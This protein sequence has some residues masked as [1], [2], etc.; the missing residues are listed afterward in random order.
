MEFNPELFR[1]RSLGFSR[2]GLKLF[3]SGKYLGTIKKITKVADVVTNLADLTDLKV[4]LQDILQNWERDL[5]CYDF[6]SVIWRDSLPL[7]YGGVFPLETY[8]V[9]SGSRS[10]LGDCIVNGVWEKLPQEAALR[11]F[12]GDLFPRVYGCKMFDYGIHCSFLRMVGIVAGN[13][14]VYISDE[15]WTF[16]GGRR[17]VHLAMG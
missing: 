13:C 9:W 7:A 10:K 11:K 15:V 16:N 14:D 12:E 8:E 6:K 3:L 5:D 17:R 1:C 4:R 2:D